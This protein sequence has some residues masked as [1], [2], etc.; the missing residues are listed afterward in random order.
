MDADKKID[1]LTARDTQ[2]AIAILEDSLALI[3]VDDFHR[4]ATEALSSVRRFLANPSEELAE[5]CRLAAGAIQTNR[6]LIQHEK[7]ACTMAAGHLASMA[8]FIWR[9]KPD[10]VAAFIRCVVR[11]CLRYSER[12]RVRDGN[13]PP[14]MIPGVVELAILSRLAA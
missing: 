9:K 14:N 11:D 8:Y 10:Q 6:V 5:A 13:Q 7:P 4:Q 12:E 3:K 2:T 1:K